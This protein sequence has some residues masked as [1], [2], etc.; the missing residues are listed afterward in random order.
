MGLTGQ[1]GL[2][3]TISPVLDEVAKGMLKVSIN[4]IPTEG[5]KVW[6]M[7]VPQGL[8]GDPFQDPNTRLQTVDAEAGKTVYI[9]TTKVANGVYNLGVM[10]T[11]NP[12]GAPWTDVV[13]TQ[14][15]V[16]N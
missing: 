6:V 5:N 4:T 1:M 9:D 13:Q 7:L 15:L 16:E 11:S 12:G 2:G 3:V 10:T 14:L 8:Q